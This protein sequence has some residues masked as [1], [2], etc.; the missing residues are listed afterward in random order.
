MH[1]ILRDSFGP[2][3]LSILPRGVS[4]GGFVGARGFRAGGLCCSNA[5]AFGLGAPLFRRLPQFFLATVLVGQFLGFATLLFCG[6]RR[7]LRRFF[8]NFVRLTAG[9]VSQAL[10]LFGPAAIII[11]AFGFDS[12]R[13]GRRFFRSRTR[14]VLLLLFQFA[15]DRIVAG[16][17]KTGAG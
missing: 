7:R 15:R 16:L 4:S 10:R 17:T 3:T 11:K 9:F 14:L 5:L 2:T 13:V 12:A 1:L 8:E 6:R